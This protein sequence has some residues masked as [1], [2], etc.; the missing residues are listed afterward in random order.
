MAPD[1]VSLAVA[2]TAPRPVISPFTT[3]FTMDADGARFAACAVDTQAA[4]VKIL[5]AASA[6]GFQGRSVCVEAL[7]A[8]SRTWGDA[9][10]QSIRAVTA[11]GGGTVTLSDT[12]ISLVALE[13]TSQAVFDRVVGEQFVERIRRMGQAELFGEGFRPARRRADGA[14]HFTAVHFLHRGREVAR[15]PAGA[16]DAPAQGAW[17]G[18]R[19]VA[20]LKNGHGERNELRLNGRGW[21]RSRP[22][23]PLINC[24]HAKTLAHF[25]RKP[26]PHLQR[27]APLRAL[28]PRQPDLLHH[29]KDP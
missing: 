29:R 27:P 20:G 7:G 25:R 28:V 23:I 12:D 9:A 6:A 11:L 4:E 16:D 26:T 1:G 14:D 2:I 3:R 13:G 17:H 19:G 10:A 21:G 8:P 18:F 22:Q 5:A 24:I 15:D